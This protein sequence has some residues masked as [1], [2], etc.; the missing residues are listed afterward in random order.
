MKLNFVSD[1]LSIN[2]FNA[3]ELPDFTVITGIN[4]AGK[5][6]LLQAIAARKV[7]IS[8]RPANLIVHFNFQNFRLQNEG[9]FSVSQL[10]V[11]RKSFWKSVSQGASGKPS[12]LGQLENIAEVALKG[13][14]LQ[15]LKSIALEKR[16]PLLSLTLDDI[17][18]S[19][20]YE[21]FDGYRNR[22]LQHIRGDSRLKN[23]QQQKAMLKLAN[24]IQSAVHEL[25]E[26]DFVELV[27]L[28]AQDGVLP[29]QLSRIFSDYYSKYDSNRYRKYRNAECGEKLDVLSEE[30]FTQRH[31]PKPWDVINEILNL[32]GTLPYKVTDP[33]GLDRNDEFTVELEHQSRS[34]VKPTFEQLSSGE[35][36]LMALVATVYSSSSAEIWPDVLLLDEVDA[37]LHPS[38]VQNLLSVLSETFVQRGTSVILVSHSPSTIALAPESS[39]FVMNAEGENRIAKKSKAEALSVLTEGFA[40]LDEGVRL[41]DQISQSGLVILTEGRNVSFLKMLLDQNEISGV[42]VMDGLTD[43]SGKSQLKS[44]FDFFSK[45]PHQTPVLVVWD[46]DANEYRGL[47]EVNSTVPFVFKQNIANQVASKGIEN[48]F[49]ESLFDGFKITVTDSLG[50]TKSN[51][52]GSRK[53]DFEDFILT[54]NNAS[55]FENFVP[56]IQCIEGKLSEKS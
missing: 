18:D 27:D 53:R 20:V 24:S 19:E 14:C 30:E 4:G 12:I 23:T 21:A 56:L 48:L 42:E 52:D 15:E 43:R 34:D 46:S 7:A 11:E 26:S 16:K 45:V 40:T 47:E 44:M 37:S 39:V 28:T 10:E 22:V 36:V 41:F 32:F 33:E 51:F 29:S 38:M 5:S 9:R 49:P 1:H 17:G 8:N 50:R 2:K 3:V 31:G 13:E 55:D 54:R 25:G 35:K 6:H